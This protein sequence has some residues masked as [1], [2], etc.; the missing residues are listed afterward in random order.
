MVLSTIECSS[1]NI[2]I[3]INVMDDTPDVEIKIT[4]KTGKQQKESPVGCTGEGNRRTGN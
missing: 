4:M 1:K 2:T 3:L